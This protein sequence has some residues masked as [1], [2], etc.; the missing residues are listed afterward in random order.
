MVLGASIF[1][2]FRVVL[3]EGSIQSRRA[4]V[5]R[6]F[7]VYRAAFRE[8]SIRYRRYMARFGAVRKLLMQM[9]SDE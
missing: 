1:P 2:A 8:I 7:S 5:S 4:V 3:R 9:P 6:L